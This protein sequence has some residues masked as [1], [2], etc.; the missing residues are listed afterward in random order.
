MFPAT[1]WRWA[2]DNIHPTTA[3]P[4]SLPSSSF[5]TGAHVHTSGFINDEPLPQFIA[6]APVQLEPETRYGPVAA[7]AGHLVVAVYLMVQASRSLHKA[8]RGLGPSQDTRGRVAWRNKLLPVFA[9]LASISL[10]RQ[11]YGLS[12]YA[13]LSYKVWASGRGVELPTQFYGN[14]GI[15]PPGENATPVYLVQWLS[16]TPIHLD[17]V[18]IIAEKARRFWWG[19]QV[20]SGLVSWSMLLAIEGRRRN[21]PLLWSYQ[22][23]GQLVSLSFAQN[24]FFVAILLTPSPLPANGNGSLR[25]SRYAR[26]RNKLFAPN[27][28]NWTPHAWVFPMILAFNFVAML[29]MPSQ[30]NTEHFKYLVLA[31]RSLS[32]APLAVHYILP[33]SWG[34]I[35]DDP[36]SAYSSY[37]QLFRAL[38]VGSF[39]L[40]VRASL[41]GLAYNAPDAYYHRHSV[42]LPF[43]LEQRSAWERTTSAFGRILGA[44]SDHP[45]VGMAGWDVIISG[46]SIGLWVATRAT[47]VSDIL[48][49]TIPAYPGHEHA[50]AETKAEAAPNAVTRGAAKALTAVGIGAGVGTGESEAEAEAEGQGSGPRR[51]GRSRKIKEDPANNAYEPAASEVAATEEGD[52]LPS[53]DLDWESAAV[54][55]G[56]TTLGGLGV[57]SAGA[58]GAEFIA[59]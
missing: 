8:Y 9:G 3:E 47:D 50:S 57:G 38:F 56:L 33:K 35:H 55:W 48:A 43:D 18:E 52:E 21:I 22:L 39:V 1:L 2:S 5:V 45:V 46:V 20:D 32:L 41:V 10:L 17:A 54:V 34:S 44:T 51:R 24:L 58:F 31:S 6:M 40:H 12:A 27:P 28:T 4:E 15:F 49:S 36:H 23:L 37:K 19:Q 16:D 29:S 25:A 30:A 13:V 53:D 7:V 26:M 11:V 42:H 14:N 59:R